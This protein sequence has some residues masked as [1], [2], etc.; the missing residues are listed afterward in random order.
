MLKS[1]LLK[2]FHIFWIISKNVEFRPEYGAKLFPPRLGIEH[3]RGG[4]YALNPFKKVHY[5][6]S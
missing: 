4:V 5:G 2:V 6:I 1:I 3:L